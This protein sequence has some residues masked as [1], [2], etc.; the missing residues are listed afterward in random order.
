MSMNEFRRLAMKID[1]YMQRLAAEGVNDA[2]STINRMM[3]YVPDLHNIWVG[4]SNDQLMALSKE[5]P[6]FYRY[7][8]MMEEASQAERDKSSRP[9]DGMTELPE[10]QKQMG[11]QLLRTAATLESG[12]QAFLG[13]GRLKLFQPQIDEMNRLYRQWLGDL[14]RFKSSLRAQGVEDKALEYMNEAFGRLTDRI[15]NLQD[16]SHRPI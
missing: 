4:T 15:K 16:Q 5:F 12:Y 13:S 6:W 7:A 3:G 10:Q 11:A 9:Y 8:L 1:Q 2:P 14:E